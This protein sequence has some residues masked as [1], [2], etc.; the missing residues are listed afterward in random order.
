[1]AANDSAGQ[2]KCI[3]MILP[4]HCR[5]VIWKRPIKVQILKPLTVSVFFFA[6]PCERISS[7][8]MALRVDVTGQDNVL[9]ACASLPL[10]ARKFYSEGVNKGR[11]KHTDGQ[12]TSHEHNRKDLNHLWLPPGMQVNTLKGMKTPS[13]HTFISS[14]SHSFSAEKKKLQRRT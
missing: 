7:K 14:C 5:D 9:F 11:C 3:L 13:S 6:L 4:I 2:S 8:H 10:S 12:K 1:M